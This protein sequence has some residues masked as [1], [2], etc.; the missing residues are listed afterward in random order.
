MDPTSSAKADDGAVVFPFPFP[1]YVI[2][3]R[4]MEAMHA[5]ILAGN[6]G[7]F[8]SPTG[9]VSAGGIQ[10]NRACHH[11]LGVFHRARLSVSSVAQ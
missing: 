8:E 5:T 6:C 3:Q 7:V 11:T 2:Q 9:T 4:F 10:P 1:P